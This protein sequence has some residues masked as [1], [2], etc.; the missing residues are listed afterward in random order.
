VIRE[1]LALQAADLLE[2]R[3]LRHKP[4][5]AT[6]RMGE[7]L[8]GNALAGEA[9]RFVYAPL[10]AFLKRRTKLP[11][12]VFGPLVAAFEL[13]AM[14]LVG[15]TPPVR[16]WRKGEVPLLFAHATAFALAV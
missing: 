5:Y 6:S 15:A 10:M 9:L 2:R 12:L 13:V 1:L 8:F 3:L 16:K 4:V 14:P 11:A 7:R